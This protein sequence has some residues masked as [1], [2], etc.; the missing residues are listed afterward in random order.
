MKLKNTGLKVLIIRF[1]SMGDIIYTTPVVRCLKKQI[2][3]I[4]IHFLTK[5]QFQ[6]IF[7]GNPYL[8][9]LHLLAD[10]L[11]ETITELRNEKFDYVIDLHNSLRS[12]LVKLQ[13]GVRSSTF[14]KMRF[15]KW[16][17][18]RFKI[19]KVPTSHLVDRYMDTVKFL[20]IQ[21]D[22]DPIDYFLPNT[23]SID[24]LLPE[25]H[26]KGYLVFI[27][28]A[29]HFTKR[30]PNYKVI[31]LCKKLS[32]PIVLLGGHDVQLNG[33][34]IASALGS[35]VY[36]ACGKLSLNESVFLVK[37]A[38]SVIGFDTGLTHIAEAFNKKI[39]SIW[40]STS[41][42]LL[43]VQPYQVDQFY[44][45]GVKLPCRPC[46][47]FGLDHCPKK[48]FKCMHDIDEKQ[49]AAFILPATKQKVQGI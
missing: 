42:E 43:G 16:L 10:K 32:L 15:R 46:S 28:G 9:K 11:S 7:D 21:N 48:H 25:S 30:M 20:G 41:P 29:M 5:K 14:N 34:E 1:S 8:D 22:G 40:G 13:L 47:K 39:V 37:E 23:F 26:R 6:F 19:N 38:Q 18:L 44:T 49:I 45:A 27:I 24:H 3:G 2:P 17:A 4:E 36:N 31:S 35:T 33:D 12:T